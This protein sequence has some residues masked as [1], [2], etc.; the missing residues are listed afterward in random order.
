MDRSQAESILRAVA[1]NVSTCTING[2][3]ERECGSLNW[4]LASPRVLAEGDTARM[5]AF[6]LAYFA[7]AGG[8]IDPRGI[9]LDQGAFL[10]PDKGVIKWALRRRIFGW[11]DSDPPAFYLTETGRRFFS[12]EIAL[13]PFGEP[14]V[15]IVSANG[16]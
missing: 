13:P 3:P 16:S 6:C 14:E 10:R 4:W 2:S 5:R 15:M 1:G 11:R 12:G 7:I 8:Q 9:P